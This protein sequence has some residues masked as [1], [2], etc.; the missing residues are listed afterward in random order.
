MSNPP[1]RLRLDDE[2]RAALAH[3][4][5]TLYQSRFDEALTDFR[6]TELIDF[7]LSHLGPA[8]YNQ[9]VA[10]ARGY[11]LERLDDLDAEYHEPEPLK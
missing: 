4:L 8:V 11:I 5:G 2:R 1:I 7:F 6:A 10:D 9:A 3:Q